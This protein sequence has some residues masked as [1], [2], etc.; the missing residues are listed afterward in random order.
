MILVVQWLTACPR[1]RTIRCR[2]M[3]VLATPLVRPGS[4]VITLPVTFPVARVT[5]PT[6]VLALRLCASTHGR[7]LLLRVV[8]ILSR[9]ALHVTHVRTGRL[10]RRPRRC[11]WGRKLG[12]LMWCE[13]GISRYWDV[14]DIG[15]TTTMLAESEESKESKETPNCATRLAHAIV[16][17]VSVLPRMALNNE[18]ASMT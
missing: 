6:R 12:W 14:P 1:M 15:F 3:R 17:N 18:K 4:V 2:R 7:Q 8:V 16:L 5:V 10:A 9:S 13:P 11:D